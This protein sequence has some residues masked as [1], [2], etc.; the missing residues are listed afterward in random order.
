MLVAMT[1]HVIPLNRGRQEQVDDTV[2]TT[3]KALM[4]GRGMSA[5]EL[6]AL[7]G[8][9][10]S[11][12]YRRLRATGSSRAFTAGELVVIAEALEVEL[13]DLYSGLGGRFKGERS[14]NDH[15]LTPHR[16]A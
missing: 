14:V 5:D 15:N 1:A 16:A 10:P 11:A 4:A 7:I 8:L 2:R 9:T 13:T 3:I 6:A 12:V